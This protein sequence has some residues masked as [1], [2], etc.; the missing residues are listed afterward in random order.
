[1]GAGSLVGPDRALV[2]P[3]APAATAAVAAVAVTVRQRVMCFTSFLLVG[4][5][6]DAVSLDLGTHD[7][8][9]S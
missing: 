3:N 6:G 5:G 4:H 9:R 7:A 1:M 2:S 8:R